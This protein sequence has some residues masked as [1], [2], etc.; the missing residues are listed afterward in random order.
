MIDNIRAT[1]LILILVV[2]VACVIKFIAGHKPKDVSKPCIAIH[3]DDG[4]TY[5]GDC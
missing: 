3:S 1:L 2:F 4:I 5:S